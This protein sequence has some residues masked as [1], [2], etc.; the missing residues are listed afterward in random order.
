MVELAYKI[1][2]NAFAGKKDKAGDPYI[3][4]LERV[5]AS[6]REDE[7]LCTI[8][9]LHD[10]IEDCPEWTIERLNDY[11]ISRVCT[12]V[13]ALTKINDETYDNYIFRVSANEDARKVKIADLKD[14]MNLARIKRIIT[15]K[16]L[17]RVAKYHK[18]YL[19][20]SHF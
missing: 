1:I 5:A 2:F 7:L 3:F 9:L 13:E 10:L 17:A 20:L 16:D 18:A 6:F 11:F 14:N 8:A 15:E 12:A 19:L 4:H